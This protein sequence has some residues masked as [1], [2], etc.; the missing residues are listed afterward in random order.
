[1]DETKD[2]FIGFFLT[3]FLKEESILSSDYKMVNGNVLVICV[4]S[5]RADHLGCYGCERDTS[6]CIDKVA[7]DGV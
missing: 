1:M 4:D 5:L 2:C 7:N 6:P 3:V